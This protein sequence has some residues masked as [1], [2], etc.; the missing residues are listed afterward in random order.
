M[1]GRGCLDGSRDLAL[2][3]LAR[4]KPSKQTSLQRFEASSNSLVMTIGTQFT[5]EY[6]L[7]LK[8]TQLQ[9]L[10][11]SIGARSSGTKHVLAT[12]IEEALRSP[13]IEESQLRRATR[14]FQAASHRILS[15]DMGI[16]NLAYCMLDLPSNWSDPI[17]GHIQQPNIGRLG[18]SLPCLHEWT[19][20]A[21]TSEGSGGPGNGPDEHSPVSKDAFHPRVLAESAHSLL[22]RLVIRPHPSQPPPDTILIERQRFR[23][24]GAAAVQEWTLRVNLFEG[25]LWAVLVAARARGD[26]N[27]RIYSVLPATTARWWDGTTASSEM[28]IGMPPKSPRAVHKSTKLIKQRRIE[29]V[30]RWLRGEVFRVDENARAATQAYVEQIAPRSSSNRA[31]TTTSRDH[32]RLGKIDDMADSLLQAVAWIRWEQNRRAILR[33]GI[34]SVDPPSIYPHPGPAKKTALELALASADQPL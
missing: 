28:D 11:V 2:R 34:D 14:P 13:K 25:M 9:R 27:G 33:D 4:R 23:T 10:A 19:R 1:F 20:L 22:N 26:W 15:M 5:T 7:T 6:L 8:A 18:D 17:A 30:G 21:V 16:R 3:V 24:M 29:R 31:S 12:E 32:M